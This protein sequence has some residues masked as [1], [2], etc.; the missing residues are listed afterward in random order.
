MASFPLKFFRSLW[1]I[2]PK[3]NARTFSSTRNTPIHNEKKKTSISPRPESWCQYYDRLRKLHVNYL[4]RPSQEPIESTSIILFPG[5]G[6]QFVG[7]AKKMLGVPG[8]K[9]MF[10]SASSILRTNIL[11]TCLEGP[12]DK[13]KLNV[14]CQPAVYVTSLA[15]VKKLQLE[16][17]KVSIFGVSNASYS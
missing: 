13:L 6:S 9:D 12:P 3:C 7:M 11:K 14:H 15:A 4:C 5:Q 16:S 17:P 10:E 2:Q 1:Y 8:V